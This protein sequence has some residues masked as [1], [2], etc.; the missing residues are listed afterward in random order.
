MRFKLFILCSMV[1]LLVACSG[2]IVHDVNFIDANT[3]AVTVGHY[4]TSTTNVW[5]TLPSGETYTGQYDLVSE[6]S[7][8]ED[9]A[10]GNVKL[11]GDKGGTMELLFAL[12]IMSG[13]GTGSAVTDK[14]DKYKVQFRW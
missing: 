1:L 7:G 14:G 4:D 12:E 10:S 6:L 9:V 2:A 3:D 8:A 13:A 11:T 5:V